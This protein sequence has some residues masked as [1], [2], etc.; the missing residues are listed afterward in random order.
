MSRKLASA[1][2]RQNIPSRRRN[3]IITTMPWWPRIV[4]GAAGVA[5]HTWQAAPGPPTGPQA[6]PPY[7]C[8]Q[9]GAGGYAPEGCG[10]GPG[11]GVC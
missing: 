2:V 10:Y 8:G 7:C 4:T 9:A 1:Q 11:P 3:R 6:P 5:P